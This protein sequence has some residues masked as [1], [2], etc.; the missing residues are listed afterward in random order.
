MFKASV[1]GEY[2]LTATGPRGTRSTQVIP[3]LITNAG[4]DLI[5]QQSGPISRAVVGTYGAAPTFTDTA[6]GAQVAMSGSAS[7]KTDVNLGS[8]NYTRE[9]TWSFTFTPMG[10]QLLREVGIYSAAV[11]GVLVS[12]AL[13]VDGGGTPTPFQIYTGDTLTLTY[14]LRVSMPQT[15]TTASVTVGGTPITLTGRPSLRTAA[16]ISGKEMYRGL[17]EGHGFG[18][19]S[20]TFWSGSLAAADASPTGTGAFLL[21]SAVEPY[22]PGSFTLTVVF[23]RAPG[24]FTSIAANSAVV[25]FGDLAD[26][27][28][29]TMF[30]QFGLS[31]PITVAPADRISSTVRVVYTRA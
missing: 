26:I 11:G 22:V 12:R 30:Y 17:S 6:L 4:M 2:I 9:L 18:P 5:A 25:G 24:A 1:S 29:N 3:N 13:I 8:P 28:S 16:P 7:V 20:F 27:N 31:A 23:T 19:I 15:D 10:G 21:Q 14:R